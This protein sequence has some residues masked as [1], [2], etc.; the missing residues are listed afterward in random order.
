MKRVYSCVAMD[1]QVRTW[2]VTGHTYNPA[3]GHVQEL[4]GLDK[5]LQVCWRFPLDISIVWACAW[6]LW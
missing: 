3:D 1:M 6:K 2:H 5:A 4:T